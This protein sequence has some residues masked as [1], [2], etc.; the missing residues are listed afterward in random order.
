MRK[1]EKTN[2]LIDA[3]ISIL[4]E[5]SIEDLPNIC[6]RYGLD[7]GDTL[8]A[9]KNKN[10]YIKKRLESKNQLFLLDLARRL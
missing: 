4:I 5:E 9:S 7:I 8:E 2:E 3:I 6:L 1:I 10:I